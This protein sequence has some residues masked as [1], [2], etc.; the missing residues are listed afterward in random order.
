MLVLIAAVS[1]IIHFLID[2][3]LYLD[4]QLSIVYQFDCVVGACNELNHE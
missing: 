4:I 3:T 1:C 2:M